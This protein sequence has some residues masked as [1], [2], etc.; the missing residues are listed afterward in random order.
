MCGAEG[1][2]GRGDEGS[3][4]VGAKKLGEKGS[5]SSH[6][7]HFSVGSWKSLD[8]K[9]LRGVEN[10]LVVAGLVGTSKLT[11]AAGRAGWE[12]C[13]ATHSCQFK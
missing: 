8:E 11:A 5:K 13:F 1:S 10:F 12:R 7:N 2:Q 9:K 3:D 6:L 4:G